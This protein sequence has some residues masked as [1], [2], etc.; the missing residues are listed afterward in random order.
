MKHSRTGSVKKAS[1]STRDHNSL[2]AACWHQHTVNSAVA[3]CHYHKQLFA[4]L[5]E[6]EVG[7]HLLGTEHGVL[8]LGQPGAA[9]LGHEEQERPTVRQL[10]HDEHLSLEHVGLPNTRA[11]AVSG[12]DDQEPEACAELLSSKT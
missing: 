1:N 10:G 2:G 11:R 12:G 9:R 3:D 8:V 5:E 7:R 6:H 4:L